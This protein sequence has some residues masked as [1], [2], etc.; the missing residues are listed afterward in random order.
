M[1]DIKWTN[2]RIRLGDLQPWEHNPRQSTDKQ[3]ERIADSH[4]LFGQ[5][6]TI[7]ID[8]DGKVL[9]GHQRLSSWL[10]EYGPDFEAD[11]RRCN[12][13]LDTEERQALTA[14]L[15]AGAVGSW[16]WDALSGWDV[17]ILQGFGF[18]ED[19]VTEWHRDAFSLGEWL[20]SEI[21]PPSLDE[22]E[23]EYGEP[24]DRDFWPFIRVQ[25]SP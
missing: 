13:K 1:T 11:V 14:M 12:R 21:E 22:L 25:G 6:E 2:D 17:E 15:H 19:L 10:A 3:A 23:Q 9:N 7:A 24:G 18:D 5:V 8:P 4:R 16:D 20:V